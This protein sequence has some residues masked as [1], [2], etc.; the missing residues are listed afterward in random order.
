LLVAAF[1]RN[2]SGQSQSTVDAVIKTINKNEALAISS[3][4]VTRKKKTGDLELRK[5][6]ATPC[7]RRWLKYPVYICTGEKSTEG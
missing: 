4:A 5:K 6:E 3:N 1:C 7:A 2:G